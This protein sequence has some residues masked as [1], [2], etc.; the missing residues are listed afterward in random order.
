MSTANSR[1]SSA[2]SSAEPPTAVPLVRTMPVRMTSLAAANNVAPLTGEEIQVADRATR[3]LHEHIRGF[4]SSLPADARNASALSR[5]LGVDRTT[6]QRFVF[7]ASRPYAGLALIDRL[8]GVRGLRQ[9]TEG[10]RN[11]SPPVDSETLSSLETAIDRFE[12][13]IHSLAPSQSALLRRIG[14]TPLAAPNA[15]GL[16]SAEPRAAR[17]RL[18]EAAAEVT[19]RFSET[20]VAVYVY[21]PGEPA[22]NG[23]INV[24]RAHGLVGH[25][26]RRDAVPLTFH[27]FV[28]KRSDGGSADAD[29]Q[30]FRNLSDTATLGNSP[31]AILRQ[32]STDPLPVVSSRQP[33]EYLVQA[34]DTNP[35]AAGLPVDL[36]LATRNIMPHPATQLPGI[37]EVWAMINFPARQMIFDVYLHRDLARQ[38]IPA[39]DAHLWRPDFAAQVAD[40]WQTRFADGPR[41]ELLG[42][43]TQ[44]AATAA[45]ARHQELTTFLFESLQLDDS[46]FVGYRGSVAYP[47]WRTGYCMSFDFSAS[48]D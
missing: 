15:A 27:N 21:Y 36:M 19:G 16:E 25:V 37:E 35:A 7:T 47:V 34:I 43:G 4:L 11:A 48:D 39:L 22:S 40:R 13:A 8:P 30:A 1:E 46:R 14:A 3:R 41:L 10:A 28:S 38:C 2:A 6:C 44:N 33:G 12:E 42:Q 5:Y 26:A 20:W 9:L 23:K 45:Y 32:F 18:F 17:E 29:D 31:D 24:A